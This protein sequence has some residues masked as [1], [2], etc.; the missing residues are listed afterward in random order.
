MK[1][2]DEIPFIRTESEDKALVKGSPK[3]KLGY[4]YAPQVLDPSYPL[5]DIPI[6]V[7]AG[8][9]LVFMQSILHGTRVNTS[10]KTRWSCDTRIVNPFHPSPRVKTGIFTPLSRCAVSKAAERYEKAS[11]SSR[12]A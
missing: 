5:K 11:A 10:M 3:H 8:Q 7:K 12:S 4:P 1:G 6:P 9:V 2:A